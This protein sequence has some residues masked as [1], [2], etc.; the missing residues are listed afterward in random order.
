MRV[1]GKTSARTLPAAIAH[2][3]LAIAIVADGQND[4]YLRDQFGCMQPVRLN[5]FSQTQSTSGGAY[6]KL[7][8]ILLHCAIGC[9]GYHNRRF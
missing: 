3:K 1:A 6:S 5:T 4:T 8:Q 2:Y 9:L 7:F